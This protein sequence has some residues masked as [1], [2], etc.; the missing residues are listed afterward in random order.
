VGGALT[1]LLLIALGTS[2]SR[3][4][5]DADRQSLIGSPT[6]VTIGPENPPLAGRRATRQL[7][8]T[9]HY[10]DGSVRDLT[11]ALSWTS[12]DPQIATVSARG[13][14]VPAGSRNGAATVVARHA[15]I[16]VST[17]INLKRMEQP[18]PVSFR[19]DVIP[20]FSQAGCNTGAVTARRP[21]REASASA[22]AGTSPI[23]ISSRSAVRREAGASTRWRPRAACS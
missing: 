11:R 14:L 6:K 12:L 15:S 7:I 8:V 23:K 5:E 9:G 2:A 18:A 16:E 21:A 22:C 13:Q 4:G 3:A 10:A 19:R 1:G 20:A 17:K